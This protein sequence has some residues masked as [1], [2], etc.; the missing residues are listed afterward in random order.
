MNQLANRQVV[1]VVRDAMDCRV[2]RSRFLLAMTKCVWLS[3]RTL[4]SLTHTAC[5]PRL[6]IARAE[7]PWRSTANH[8]PKRQAV[9]VPR[10]TM[11]CRVR[12]LRSLLAMTKCVGVVTESYTTIPYSFVIARAYARGDPMVHSKRTAHSNPPRQY[13]F[14]NPPK[15]LV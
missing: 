9:R 4:Y 8:K 13:S 14:D 1:R 12:R 2:V 5:S 15:Y 7:S 10:D 11:D 6:V 3:N